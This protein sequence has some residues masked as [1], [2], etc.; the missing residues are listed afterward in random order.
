MPFTAEQFFAVFA[1]YN[2]AIWPLQIVACLAG[3]LAV[4]FLLRPS[5]GAGQ[6]IATVLALFWAMNGLGY[7][8]TWFAPINPVA[9]LFAAAFVAEAVLL[10]LAPVL[11]RELRFSVRADARSWL[12]LALIAYALVLYPA[13]GALAGHSWPEVPVFGV[14][15]CPTV[16][17]T[18]GMLLLAPWRAARWLL[19]VPV[20]WSAVGGSAATLLGVPQ[21]YGLIVAGL[22][23][24]AVA[25]GHRFRAG[26]ARHG[27]PA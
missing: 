14:A 15:P 9:R 2:Q 12:G 22:V 4:A 19:V 18:I 26:F 20:L 23:A 7:H 16:I 21:D 17:F 11:F 13:L 10:A 8:W 6:G 5:R 3:L 25:L 27:E 1:A 24:L